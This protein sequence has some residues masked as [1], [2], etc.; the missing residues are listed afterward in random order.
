LERETNKKAMELAWRRQELTEEVVHTT[1][2]RLAGGEPG[3]TRHW[4]DP[5]RAAAEQ[6]AMAA[7][8]AAEREGGAWRQAAA[9][10]AAR[11]AAAAAAAV[12]KGRSPGKV[13]TAREEG[14]EAG[15]AAL[16]DARSR[17]K[18]RS[19]LHWFPHDGVRVVHAD[20]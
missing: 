4:D 14:L 10:A 6:A 8:I 18:A 19:L 2:G 9:R 17:S 12:V 15:R 1:V 13:K 20:A 7:K 5:P 3:L 16:A 11:R